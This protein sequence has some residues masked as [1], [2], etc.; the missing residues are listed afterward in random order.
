MD[1]EKNLKKLSRTPV[2]MNFVK[3]HDACWDHQA[4]LELCAT[5]E[6]KGYSPI[7]HEEVGALL[8]QKKEAYLAK[9]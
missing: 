8:E 9:K 5:L 6:E 2:L 3:K 1:A 7:N 4:W